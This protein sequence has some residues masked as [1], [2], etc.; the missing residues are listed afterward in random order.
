MKNPKFKSTSPG[1]IFLN[2]KAT[3]QLN[4][5]LKITAE[6]QA[7]FTFDKDD[8][9]GI[10]EICV[11]DGVVLEVNGNKFEQTGAYKSEEYQSWEA[12]FKS[13]E[14]IFNIDIWKESDE[15]IKASILKKGIKQ[16]I[17]EHSKFQ[18]K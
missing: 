10:E 12:R 17:N 11:I 6:Y 18:L 14:E 5:N 9:W 4:P 2:F 16:F 8:V 7:I 15:K 1:Y 3:T 13:V